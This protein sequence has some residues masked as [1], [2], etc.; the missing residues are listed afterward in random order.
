MYLH[1]EPQMEST[2]AVLQS[3]P[4]W[5][6]GA[7]MD[8]LRL[9]L[10]RS[11]TADEAVEVVTEA[12]SISNGLTIEGFVEE[13]SGQVR[14][15]MSASRIRQTRTQAMTGAAV[16]PAGMAAILRDHGAEAW[17]KYRRLNGTLS[18]ACEHGG[19]DIASLLTTAAGSPG[20]GRTGS[21]N[22]GSRELGRRAWGCS[23]R[24]RST[25][26]WSS[27]LVPTA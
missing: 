8:L 10:E 27:G 19:S 3:R 23:S 9:A 7:E 20:C 13:H 14:T 18:M 1:R 25:G 24:L 21:Q 11:H 16:G 17:P 26:R 4:F 6:W 22:I 2:A 12:R 15:K 5:M